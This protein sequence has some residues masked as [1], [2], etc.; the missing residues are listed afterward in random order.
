MSSALELKLELRLCVEVQRQRS[1][2]QAA[3]RFPCPEKSIQTQNGANAHVFFDSLRVSRSSSANGRLFNY[4]CLFYSL[5]SRLFVPFVE[6]L[7]RSCCFVQLIWPIRF[8]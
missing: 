5:G 3:K 1:A 8:G 6:L 2:V 4:Y 7:I